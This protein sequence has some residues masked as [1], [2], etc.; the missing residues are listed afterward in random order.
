[1]EVTEGSTDQWK[2]LTSQVSETE[3]AE[4]DHW[5]SLTSQTSDQEPSAS[6]VRDEAK[7]TP[8]ATD[9]GADTLHDPS[10]FD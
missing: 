6:G 5:K 10:H 4:Q 8:L 9:G 7:L 3:G 1:M 2:S